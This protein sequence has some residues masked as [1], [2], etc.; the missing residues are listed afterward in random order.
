MD[1]LETRGGDYAPAHKRITDLVWAGQS[2]PRPETPE[3]LL[4]AIEFFASDA[5][6]FV[7]GQVLNVDGGW[8]HT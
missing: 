1:K 3:D 5:L 6:G 8:T 2:I 4:G 7:T